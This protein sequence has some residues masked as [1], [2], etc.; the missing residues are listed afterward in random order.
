MHDYK[1]VSTPQDVNVKFFVTTNDMT[2]EEY[3][4]MQ[5]IPFQKLWASL[6]L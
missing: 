4:I 6:C 1:L 3:K 2:Q 5:E